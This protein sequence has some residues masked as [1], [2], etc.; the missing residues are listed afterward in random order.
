MRQIK[1]STPTHRRWW[2]DKN[3]MKLE[4][5]NGRM[6]AIPENQKDV[7]VLMK[8]SEGVRVHKE[9]KKHNHMKTCSLCGKS[10]KGSQGLGTHYAKHKRER[11]LG[12]PFTNPFN[13]TVNT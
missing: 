2:I 12:N 7:S 4:I 6:V 10:Y 1:H 8:L 9:H 11:K 5:T 13:Q 3:N